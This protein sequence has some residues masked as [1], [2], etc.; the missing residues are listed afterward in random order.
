MI[1]RDPQLLEEFAAEP[2]LL[3]V[4]DALGEALRTRPQ[5]RRRL[6]PLVTAVAVAAVAAAVALFV[7]LRSGPGLTDRALAAIGDEPV[8]HVVTRQT[9][10]DGWTLVEIATGRRTEQL[11]VDE[12]EIWFDPARGLEHTITRTN[13]YLADDILQTPSGTTD[14]GGTV[15]TCA[16]IARHP[17]EATRAGVSCNLSGDNGATPRDVPEAPAT[18]DPALAGFVNGYR[19]ALASGAARLSGE[20]IVDGRPVYWLEL[21]AA[22][23]M[24]ERVAVDRETYKPL[25]VRTSIAG[26]VSQEYR[27][28]EIDTVG[29]A[30]ADFSKPGRRHLPTTANVVGAAEIELE[31]ARTLLGR[32]GLWAGPEVAGL[33][34]ALVRRQEVRIGFGPDSG[35]P[36][37]TGVALD[38][39]YGQVQNGHATDDSVEITEATEPALV[40][41]WPQPWQPPL[42]DGYLR[43][44]PFGA[45]LRRDSLYVQIFKL[46]RSADVALQVA[47]QLEPIPPA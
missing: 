34:L 42:R 44:S 33:K 20:G 39:V 16:T 21:H 29:R 13:G 15:W 5:S 6:A 23:N 8:L 17:V 10:S 43:S 18:L 19:D 28:L 14:L 37:R 45:F 7:A 38:L 26:R 46:P 24:N 31:Q 35:I 32:A 11:R 30:D 22:E 2:E 47:R 3:A 1:V 40:W 12:N 4:A 41:A 9:S 36:P 27:V 25:L